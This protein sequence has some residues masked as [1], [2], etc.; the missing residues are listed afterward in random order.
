MLR[1]GDGSEVGNVELNG[2]I[3]AGTL[4]VKAEEE[5]ELL[6][7]EPLK[8]DA[9]LEAVGIPQNASGSPVDGNK[10]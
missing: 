6:K 9:L 5:W 4:M 8:L 7:Q 3:L 1:R 10:L 2:T